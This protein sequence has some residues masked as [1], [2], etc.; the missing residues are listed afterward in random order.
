MKYDADDLVEDVILLCGIGF[1]FVC[2][3]WRTLEI[4]CCRYQEVLL[5]LLFNLFF[6]CFNYVRNRI[7][8]RDVIVSTD[9]HI[10]GL[11]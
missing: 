10:E 11:R 6:I 5:L 8:G 9:S 3:Y 2:H 7:S 1:M 4:S